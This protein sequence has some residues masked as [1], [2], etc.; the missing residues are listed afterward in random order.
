MTNS[1]NNAAK[2][3]YQHKATG[4]FHACIKSRGVKHS[5]GYHRT[6]TEARA[7]YLS[8][9]EKHHNVK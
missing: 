2:G 5:L 9:K 1:W 3:Y 4:L 8:A 6:E 7:A